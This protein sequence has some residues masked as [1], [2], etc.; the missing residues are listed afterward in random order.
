M[1]TYEVTI[2]DRNGRYSR[3]AYVKAEN[4]QQAHILARLLLKGN[5]WIKNVEG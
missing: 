4:L 2:N 1:K 5:E 3:K